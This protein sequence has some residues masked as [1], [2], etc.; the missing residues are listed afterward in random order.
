V[1]SRIRVPAKVNLH[2]EVLGRRPDGYHELRT[3]LQSVDLYDELTVGASVHGTL[4]LDVVPAGAVD[5]GPENLVLRA[6]REVWREMGTRPGAHITLEKRIPVGGGLGGGS[7]N[8]AASLILL[9]AFWSAGLDRQALLRIAAGLGSDVP[10][11]LEGGLA[12]GVGRGE[13]IHPLADLGELGI[14]LVVPDLSI[15]T[16]EVYGRLDER[17]TSSRQRANVMDLTADLENGFRWES[18]VND[19][20]PV[21]LHGWPEVAEALEAVRATAPLHAAVSGS[22]AV[23]YGVYPDRLAAGSAADSLG[24]G[25]SVHAGA[26][27]TRARS[28]P[29][30][31]SWEAL[32]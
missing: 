11:F 24:L 1:R 21:V 28:R 17:L 7:A 2:L 30:V 25:W 22:G 18:L 20:Q 9:E 14:V 27:L 13:E 12:L 16:A 19:L 32:T 8:A 31:E 5:C 10:F 29:T 6:A 15:S 3:L 4:R 26:T 23:V